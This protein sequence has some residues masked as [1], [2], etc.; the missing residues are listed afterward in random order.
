MKNKAFQIALQLQESLLKSRQVLEHNRLR[1]YGW[2]AEDLKHFENLVARYQKALQKKWYLAAGRT[3]QE[4]ARCICDLSYG[5]QNGRQFSEQL[6]ALP[7]LRTLM[8]ELEQLD[9]E[10]GPYEYDAGT[11]S[12]TTEDIELEEVVMG[13][14][15]IELNI[16]QMVSHDSP[17]T[18]VATEPNPASRNISTTHPHVSENKLCEGEGK[19]PIRKALEQGRI[20]DFFMLVAN[21]LNTYNPDSAY[22]RLDDWSGEQCYDCGDSIHGD[23]IYYCR[24]CDYEFCSYCSS[25]CRNCDETCCLG[26]G[27]ECPECGDFVCP[28]CVAA[29]VECKKKYC[30][31]CLE[32]KMCPDCRERS[33]ENEDETDEDASEGSEISEG[34]RAAQAAQAPDG[35]LSAVQPN[36]VGEA[37]VFPGQEPQ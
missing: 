31:N 25:Y 35:V 13:P 37:V 20:C 16:Q 33:Q 28:R 6:P 3:Q 14:F 1:Q 8:A 27:G 12:V 22:I 29:C 21:T 34:A 36:G 2:L 4:V 24:S 10:L 11:L 7:S 19:I 30:V 15:K 26:C 9:T 18:C 32:E 23:D 17:Y 5:F